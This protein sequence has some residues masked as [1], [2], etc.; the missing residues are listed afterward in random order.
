M[1]A[2]T[3]TGNTIIIDLGLDRGE[4]ETYRSPTRPTVPVWFGPVLIAVLILISSAASAAPPPPPL[5]TLLS[6]RVGPADSYAVTDKGQLLAQSVG[7]LSMYDLGS[8]A[9]RWRSDSTAPMYRMRTGAGLVLLRPWSTGLARIGS[10]GTTAISLADGLAQWRRAGNVVTVAGSSA[11]LAVT[12]VPGL[13]GSGRRVQDN[14]DL[15]DPI[16]GQTRWQVAIPSTAAL[17]GVPGPAGA[18]GRM[19]LVHD[20]G[21]AAV[22][23]LA[24]GERLTTGPLPPADYGPENLTVSGG[25]ILLRHPG[26]SGYELTAYDPVTLGLRW[27]QPVRDADEVVSCGAF[28]CLTGADGVRALDPATGKLFWYRS[29]WRSVEQRGSA[30]LA[31][32]APGSSSEAVGIIDPGTGRVLVDLHGWRPVSGTG[33]AGR[34]L[35]TKVVEVGARTMVAVAGPG[36]NRPRPIADLPAGTGDCQ[37][38][39][40]RLVCRSM[41]GELVV[42]AYRQKG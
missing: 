11:L 29:G 37:A 18:P 2:D 10:M 22:H 16:T 38:V 19:L 3:L 28:A 30:V 6:L 4:P 34:L 41:T 7:T 1:A 12:I 42:W 35:V 9:L 32:S 39:P 8:G 15:V 25:L 27:S 24:T 36:D 26:A 21:T 40:G 20:D 23:D 31:Y 17:L 14:V 5:S 33:G 13:G